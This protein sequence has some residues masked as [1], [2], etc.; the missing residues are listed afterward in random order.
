MLASRVQ[1]PTPRYLVKEEPTGAP[2]VAERNA[3]LPD[4][5]LSKPLHA[6]RIRCG[7]GF[8]DLLNSARPPGE[9]GKDVGEPRQELDRLA[10]DC[11]Y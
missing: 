1:K 10:I 5:Q 2:S 4:E 9:F 11:A 3:H 7:D 8:G 6:R